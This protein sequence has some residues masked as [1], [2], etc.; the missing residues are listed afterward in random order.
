M[1]TKQIVDLVNRLRQSGI[2][3]SLTKPKSEF[4]S[5]QKTEKHPPTV[6]SH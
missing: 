3:V 2:K 6:N 4:F 1:A 5:L